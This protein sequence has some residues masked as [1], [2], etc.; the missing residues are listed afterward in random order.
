[1][2]Q[3]DWK[4]LPMPQSVIDCIHYKARG[5]PAQPI[6]TDCRGKPIGDVQTIFDEHDNPTE[7]TTDEKIPG[8]ML[9]EDG[10]SSKIPDVD[11]EEDYVMPDMD[12]REDDF[13]ITPPEELEEPTN[14]DS[15]WEIVDT[16]TTDP[17]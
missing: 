3:R 15:D 11:M 5:Q 7:I 8:V 17:I 12:V 1:M 4:T 10:E 6:F 16:T 13:D 14:T 9:P 2:V